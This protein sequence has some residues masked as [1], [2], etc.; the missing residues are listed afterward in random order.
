MP[1]TYSSCIKYVLNQGKQVAEMI[2][3]QNWFYIK[4]DYVI[5]GN[6]FFLAVFPN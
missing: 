6:I 4:H 2:I 3:S 1:K 5:K